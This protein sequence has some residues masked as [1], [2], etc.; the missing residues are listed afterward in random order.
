MKE[1]II[2]IRDSKRDSTVKG[3]TSFFLQAIEDE[4]REQTR[5]VN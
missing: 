1:P 4:Q 2:K 5:K 3:S